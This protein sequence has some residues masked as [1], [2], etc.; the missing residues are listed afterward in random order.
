MK[1]FLEILF[2][3][4]L[5]S[6]KANSTTVTTIYCESK[7]W[8][9][10][11]VSLNIDYESNLVQHPTFRAGKAFPAII[12]EKT[13]YFESEGEYWLI[14]RVTGKLDRKFGDIHQIAMCSKNK[15]KIKQK[16]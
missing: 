15:P 13:I 8:A 3:S 1:K 10:S 12:T 9:Q 11:Y 2:L 7:F 6:G 5:L 16:F 4:L 14:N